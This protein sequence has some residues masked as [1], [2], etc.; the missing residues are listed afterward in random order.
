[1]VQKRLKHKICFLK[2]NLTISSNKR[3]K[4]DQ[5]EVWHKPNLAVLNFAALFDKTQFKSRAVFL[6]NGHQIESIR[7]N[8]TYHQ[9]CPDLFQSFLTFLDDR[10][11]EK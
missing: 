3:S 11:L 7:E 1:M 6:F 5:K 2:R 9:T 8:L 4:S 10:F